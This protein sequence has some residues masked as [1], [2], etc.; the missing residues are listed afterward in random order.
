MV[1]SHEDT[2]VQA[3]MDTMPELDEEEMAALYARALGRVERQT[4]LAVLA[5]ETR[6]YNNR[7]MLMV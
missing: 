3:R 6:E 5:W 2:K 1:Y 4:K 7:A